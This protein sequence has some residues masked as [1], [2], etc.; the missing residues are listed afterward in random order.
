M[1]Y[2]YVAGVSIGSVNASY[3]ALF[4]KGQEKEAIDSL[5]ALYDGRPTSDFFKMLKYSWYQAFRKDHIA[6][7]KAFKNI[8]TEVHAGKPFQRGLSILSCDLTSGQ[9]L[10]FDETVSDEERI[11]AIIS[12]TAISMAFKPETMG[13]DDLKLVD[14]SLFSTVSIGDPIERCREDGFADKDIIIDVILC[15]ADLYDVPQWEKEGLRWN[16]A[17]DLYRRRKAISREY[18]FKEDVMR[19]MYQNDHVQFRMVVSPS[20]PLTSKGFVPLYATVEDLANE[21]KLG[22]K[23][24]LAAVEQLYANGGITNL[25]Q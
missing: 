17:L 11:D 21:K 12:S 22:Y 25:L 4:P 18:Y 6:T 1:H 8:L 13:T 9:I 15:Y 23:D 19:M 20:Q 7:N 16:S 2:D 3:F 14:G 5:A 10:I 24:G